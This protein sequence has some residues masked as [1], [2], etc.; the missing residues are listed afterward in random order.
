MGVRSKSGKLDIY[1]YFYIGLKHQLITYYSSNVICQSLLLL[2]FFQWYKCSHPVLHWSCCN[3]LSCIKLNILVNFSKYFYQEIFFPLL[4]SIN[5]EKRNPAW[6]D[7]KIVLQ[8]F[9][10]LVFKIPN[11]IF[12][13]T[14]GNTF[15][16]CWTSSDLGRAALQNTQSRASASLSICRRVLVS[17]SSFWTEPQ[18]ESWNTKC[19][20]SI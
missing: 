20:K 10:S 14:P 17:S 7:K 4:F 19:M 11:Q 15:L 18:S 13:V 2:E 9:W 5:A 12:S 8:W 6:R 16:T 1:I 3:T